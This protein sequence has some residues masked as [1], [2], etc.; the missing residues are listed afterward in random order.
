MKRVITIDG[1]AAT[2]KSTAMLRLSRMLGWR[3]VSTG[4]VYRAA[5]VLA[6]TEGIRPEE[7]ATALS[8]RLRAGGLE[9]DLAAQAYAI[10]LSSG[11]VVML[12]TVRLTTPEVSAATPQYSRIAEVR[13][14]LL[15]FQRGL[16]AEPGLVADGRDCGTVIFP[17]ARLKV[18]LEVDPVEAA[19]R[20]ER[21]LGV[22][23][24][25]SYADVLE[26]NHADRNRPNPM[27]PAP[28]ALVIDT[29]RLTPD[30]VV[31]VIA[32]LARRRGFDGRGGTQ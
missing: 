12:D 16:Y 14:A 26:R 6:L 31:A 15:D 3:G 22:G 5:T 30:E 24:A 13:A 4:H 11:V 21:G 27:T 18:W 28:D 17:D 9:Y 20:L 1:G 32:E 8:A 10:R 7:A 29:T 25:Q 2:G 19:R 23:F